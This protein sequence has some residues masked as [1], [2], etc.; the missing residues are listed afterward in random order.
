M[1]DLADRLIEHHIQTLHKGLD[2]LVDIL[3]QRQTASITITPMQE[4]TRLTVAAPTAPKKKAAKKATKKATKKLNR[5]PAEPVLEDDDEDDDDE[6]PARQP[7]QKSTPAV[8][9]G[10]AVDKVGVFLT[11]KGLQQTFTGDDVRQAFDGGIASDTL[12]YAMDRWTARGIIERT[13]PGNRAK[14]A[15]YKKIGTL[16]KDD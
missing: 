9:M 13:I 2:L 14:P 1:S 3:K 8:S 6:Q 11:K 4:P 12:K 16:G 15:T 7:A 10:D 5:R